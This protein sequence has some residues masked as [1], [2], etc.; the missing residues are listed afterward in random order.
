MVELPA[1][2]TAQTQSSR[3]RRRTASSASTPAT[4]SSTPIAL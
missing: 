3:P 4:S 2:V 1:T